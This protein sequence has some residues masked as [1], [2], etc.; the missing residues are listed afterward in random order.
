MFSRFL[1]YLIISFLPF[2]VEYA[3]GS[4]TTS[5]KPKGTIPQYCGGAV[6]LRFDVAHDVSERDKKKKTII[7][8]FFMCVASSLVNYFM[9]KT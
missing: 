6:V 5:L 3:S 9:P 8:A 7:L 4:L 1:S 2:S